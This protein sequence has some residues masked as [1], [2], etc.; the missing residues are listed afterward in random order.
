L[1][2]RP[3]GYSFAIA[4]GDLLSVF[5][6]ALPNV[7]SVWVRVVDEVTGAVFEP[8]ITANMAPTKLIRCASKM[9]H[10]SCQ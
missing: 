2:V 6:V 7:G 8:E 10:R 4:P 3:D 1:K 5:I 9:G